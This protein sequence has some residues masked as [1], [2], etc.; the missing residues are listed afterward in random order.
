MFSPNWN[1][2]RSPEIPSHRATRRIQ[3]KW[4]QK[5]I[6]AVSSRETQGAILALRIKEYHQIRHKPIT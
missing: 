1:A 6:L 4:Q 5:A 2:K 3:P